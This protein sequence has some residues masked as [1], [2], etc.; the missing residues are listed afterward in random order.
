MWILCANWIFRGLENDAAQTQVTILSITG[1]MNYHATWQ[2]GTYWRFISMNF[3]SIVQR[4]VDNFRPHQ[5]K[6]NTIGNCACVVIL[7]FKF[8][9]NLIHN[10]NKHFCHI[11]CATREKNWMDAFGGNDWTDANDYKSRMAFFY[12]H[13]KL[14]F[15]VR[16]YSWRFSR[17]KHFFHVVQRSTIWVSNYV[18]CTLSKLTSKQW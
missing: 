12:H 18:C 3:D 1:K 15:S 14:D 8:K 5:Q 16:F 13:F 6:L 10:I 7:F 4:A 11:R 17:N 2:M 9:C